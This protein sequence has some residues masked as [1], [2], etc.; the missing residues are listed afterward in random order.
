MGVFD[1]YST[2]HVFDGAAYAYKPIVD[3]SLL[4]RLTWKRRVVLL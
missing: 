2:F 4:I 3:R 1:F